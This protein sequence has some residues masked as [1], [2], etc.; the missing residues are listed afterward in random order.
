ML[1]LK[2]RA[3][4]VTFHQGRSDLARVSWRRPPDVPL[5]FGGPADRPFEPLSEQDVA[6]PIYQTF[7]KIALRNP[8]GV[9][10]TDGR[11]TFTYAEMQAAIGQILSKL[12]NNPPDQ[13]IGILLYNS[14]FFPIALMA[15]LAAGRPC[16]PLDLY[17]PFERNREIIK[18]AGIKVL[19]IGE[20]GADSAYDLPAP[21]ECIRIDQLH[22]LSAGYPT[23]EPSSALDVDAPAVVLYTSGSAGRPKGIVNSQRAIAQRAAQHVNSGHI[24]CDDRFLPL[25]SPC[26]IAGL[27]EAVT[28]LM[29]GASL[30]S[31]DPQKVGLREIRRVMYAAQISVC[32]CVPALFRS[33]L[34]IDSSTSEFEFLRI[35]RIG[36]ERILATDIKMLRSYLPP[37]CHIQ[38]GYSSTE[39][40]G[41]QL[42][43]RRETTGSSA[44][45]PV[46]YILPGASYAIV[47]DDGSSARVGEVGELVIRSPYVALGQWA[48]G[49]VV[50]GSMF[51]DPNNPRERI[52]PVGDLASVDETGLLSVVGR[53]DRQVKVRGSRVEPAE[54]EVVLR[55]A[56]SVSDAAV[57]VRVVGASN[58]LVAFVVPRDPRSA[59][60]IGRKLA[61]ELKALIRSSL[62]AALRPSDIHVLPELPRLPSS[63][64]DNAALQEIDR[65][66]SKATNSALEPQSAARPHN[67]QRAVTNS[68]RRVLGARSIA[69]DQTWEEANGDSLK[70]LMFVFDLEEALG[71][72]VSIDLFEPTMRLADFVETTLKAVAIGDDDVRPAGLQTLFLFPGVLGDDPALAA[73]RCDLAGSLRP[74][75]LRYPELE[76]MAGK[77]TSFDAMVTHVVEQIFRSEPCGPL[78]L[79]GYSFGGVLAYAAARRLSAAGYKVGFLGIIDTDL[80]HG[81][82][83][84]DVQFAPLSLKLELAQLP[85]L[86]RRQNR[87][88]DAMRVMARA[89]VSWN[90]TFLLRRL[91]GPRRLHFASKSR[92]AVHSWATRYVR[93]IAAQRFLDGVSGDL[94]PIAATLFRSEQD[95]PNA[96]PNLGWNSYVSAVRPVP[97]SGDHSTLWYSANRPVLV[98]GLRHALGLQEP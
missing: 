60:A 23:H 28:P 75:T 21:V 66:L 22:R 90:A 6:R 38:I 77:H 16:V 8:D 51:P 59:E 86:L 91:R 13:A 89:L 61:A 29:V 93:M 2:K 97:V 50:E 14:A 43:V 64:I 4:P 34:A 25:S 7:S 94:L 70:F 39:T 19:L 71:K 35:F 96:E 72:R 49:R 31:L 76:A 69:L 74:V 17:Y 87:R 81:M 73:F 79:I 65:T 88:D 54:L 3:R 48:Y 12:G 9:A 36:G 55:S 40:T 57:I 15:C 30:Y 33:L 78:Q 18:E 20:E 58:L 68:W 37:T 10:V 24:N 83:A 52:F 5:D 98:D 47:R 11:D 53:K 84:H 32:W 67:V 41:A 56:E 46:G 27:R 42:F 45:I 80:S 82:A 92:Y 44:A 95:R 1:R 62:P 63:K 26:T 85:A